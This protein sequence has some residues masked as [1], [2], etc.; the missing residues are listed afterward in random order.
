LTDE[1]LARIRPASEILPPALY[2]ALTKRPR[3]RPPAAA[4]KQQVTMRLDADV[5]AGLRAT[6]AGW[7][8]RVNDVLREWLRDKPSRAS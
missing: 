3:G 5:V 1:E 2:E 6:G 8:V 4:P 7:Q